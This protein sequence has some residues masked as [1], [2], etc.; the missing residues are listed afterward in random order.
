M[1]TARLNGSKFHEGFIIIVFP[2]IFEKGKGILDD[3]LSGGERGV[4][5]ALKIG[6]FCK[7]LKFINNL[8]NLSLSTKL[9]LNSQILI[10]NDTQKVLPTVP[11]S[12]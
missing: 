5:I 6:S 8:M 1:Y 7:C 4:E 12:L 10:R 2:E 9:F 11:I 3:I